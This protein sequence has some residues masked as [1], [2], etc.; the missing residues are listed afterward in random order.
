MMK[1]NQSPK[2]FAVIG[3]GGFIAPR[4]LEAIK[5]TGNNLVAALDPKDSV[6]ILDSFSDK[7]D[8]FTE[9]ER[10]ERHVEK[11]RRLN[12]PGKI[13]FVSICSPNYLH[14]AH[15]RFALRVGADVICEKPLVINPWNLD[16]L[17]EVE[18]EMGVGKVNTVL[19]LRVHPSILALKKKIERE[20][21]SKKYDIDLTYITPRGKWYY[22]SWKG[23]EKKS[24]GVAM[25]IGVHFFDM[26]IWIFGLPR[27]Q[28]VHYSSDKKIVGFIELE[29]ARVRWFLSLDKRDL[30]EEYR[31]K[32]QSYRCLTIDGEEFEFSSG[33]E[34]LHTEVYRKILAGEGF[35]IEDTRESISLVY[36]L[37]HIIPGMPGDGWG[38][39][40]LA[41]LR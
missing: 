9:F 36:N 31:M 33:F 10:F 27:S 40:M 24:G 14:D 38:H 37:R 28:E 11:L 4:H 13:D 34:N 18:E 23:D 30:P 16:A 19:Q 7:V 22:V 17:K 2:N 5:D 15:I 39:P 29:K 1:R 25:N 3:V 32:N 41:N 6:G 20:K 21:R 26:L 12:D 35:G 8:F